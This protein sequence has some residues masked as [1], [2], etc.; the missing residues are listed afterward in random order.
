MA[1]DLF[2]G[3]GGGAAG[4]KEF[5]SSNAQTI[6][7]SYERGRYGGLTPEWVPLAVL[8]AVVLVILFLARK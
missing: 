6:F 4:D 7:G 3:M 1:L 2:G 5:G 8:G